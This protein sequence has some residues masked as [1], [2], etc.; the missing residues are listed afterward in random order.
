MVNVNLSM[1]YN[2]RAFRLKKS[3]NL[4]EI[5]LKYSHF[6]GSVSFWSFLHGNKVHSIHK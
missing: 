2:K 1:G 6:S 3:F 4:S 5:N